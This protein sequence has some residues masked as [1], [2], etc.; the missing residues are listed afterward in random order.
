MP[1]S[2]PTAALVADEPDHLVVVERL[3]AEHHSFV[4]RVAGRFGVAPHER[5]DVVQDVFLVVYHALDRYE[6]RGAM[7]SWLFGITRGV[8][9]NR[10]RR[11]QRRR[12]SLHALP[13]PETSRDLEEVEAAQLLER[14]LGS[15]SSRHRIAFEL[16]EIEGLTGPEIS[17]AT[18]WKLNTVYTRLRAAR[19]AFDTFTRA[20]A[21]E[22][23]HG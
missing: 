4:W 9:R 10:V 16:S 17:K 11:Q 22:G 19:R 20:H 6:H 3:Y 18:G 21:A 7:T 5:E 8:A 23:S 15:V 1:A 12:R 2:S 13:P 14:F